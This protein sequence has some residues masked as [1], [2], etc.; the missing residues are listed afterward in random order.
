M[1]FLTDSSYCII[2]YVHI[3]VDREK[4]AGK[5]GYVCELYTFSIKALENYCCE[6]VNHLCKT[7]CWG[8]I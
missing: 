7:T 3:F 1:L 4:D 6:P 2:Y 8:N 5:E